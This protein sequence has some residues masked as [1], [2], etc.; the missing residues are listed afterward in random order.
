MKM[1]GKITDKVREKCVEIMNIALSINNE[2]RQQ[3]ITGNKPTVFVGFSG[4]TA[5]LDIRFYRDGYNDHD[6]FEMQT[7]YLTNFDFIDRAE[8]NI[9]IDL[10][11]VIR[12]L[13]S[14]EDNQEG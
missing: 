3:D 13:R 5:Q 8:E 4:H 7:I 6:D 14:L 11:R 2:K 1:Q 10:D 9:L 12:K